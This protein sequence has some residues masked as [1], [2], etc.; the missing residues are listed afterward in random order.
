MK[1]RVISVILMVV[2]LLATVVAPM[3]A[4][5]DKKVKILQVN[6]DGARL[7]RGPS[8]NYDVITSLKKGAKVFYMGKM[9]N[10]FAYIC[11][12]TGKL[13]YMYK[14]YL[15]SY[16]SCYKS[17]I[18]YNKK[19]TSIAVYKKANAKS[20]RVTSVGKKQYVIVYQIKGSWAYIKTLNGKG[21]Y[22]KAKY[23]K[24]A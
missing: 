19:N 17:Q 13:G 11:T 22:V 10:S 23:L 2:L 3:S 12:S 20:K 1:R 9:E 21:G 8:I 15:Q 18:Y 16:G 5:A 4:Y 24:K 6:V 7:R 14:G